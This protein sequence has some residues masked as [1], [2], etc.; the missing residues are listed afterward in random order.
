MTI[1][2]NSMSDD[3]IEMGIQPHP[4]I[5]VECTTTSFSRFHDKYGLVCAYLFI[6]INIASLGA[7]MALTFTE[8]GID[9]DTLGK[10]WLNQG[11]K[12]I[13]IISVQLLC[14]IAVQKYNVKVNYTRKVMHIFYFVVPQ[15]LDTE[16]LPFEKNI[17]T[18]AWNILIVF[19]VL[20]ATLQP[21]RSRFKLFQLLFKAIDRPEDQPYTVFWFISQLFVSIVIISGFSILYQ[22]LD[23]EHMIF[24]PLIIL[25]V[26]DGLAE[27][28]GTKWGVHK[29][30]VKGFLVN[31]NYTRSV[32][33]SLCVVIASIG[34][35]FIYYDEFNKNSIS[36][37]LILLP[38]LE[39]LTEA[40]AP[41]TWDNPLI[42]LVGY[43]ILLAAYYIGQS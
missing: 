7:L 35:I 26:G 19:L 5:G 8:H 36:F 33:G 38:L 16:L 31:R 32:E 27:P 39:T 9:N 40:K 20:S 2:T 6:V 11:I 3:I 42:L 30:N 37:T 21:L 29:Y 34:S 1:Q 12:Y 4:S 15:L 18:E 14:G 23:I 24:I 22:Y 28:V 13:S 10:F 43:I 41:H 25:I 17:F